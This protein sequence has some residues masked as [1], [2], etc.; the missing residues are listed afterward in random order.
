M[1]ARYEVTSNMPNNS[2]YHTSLTKKVTKQ[3]V[4]FRTVVLLEPHNL[5]LFFM[6]NSTSKNTF[7]FA[8]SV[9]AGRNFCELLPQLVLFHFSNFTFSTF[10]NF[11]FAFSLFYCSLKSLL[12]FL[13]S[14]KTINMVREYRNHI[15]SRQWFIGKWENDGA[16]TVKITQAE[17]NKKILGV[18]SSSLHIFQLSLA[19]FRK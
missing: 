7:T 3:N 11:L 8:V 6:L 9:S 17:F 5:T 2:L 10:S 14:S 19:F 15:S 18:C 4:S 16:N 1:E 13:T 12:N